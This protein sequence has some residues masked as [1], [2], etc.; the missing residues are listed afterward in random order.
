MFTTAGR[1]RSRPISC[2]L[3]HYIVRSTLYTP[4]LGMSFAIPLSTLVYV[5]LLDVVKL[6]YEYAQMRRHTEWTQLRSVLLAYSS[7]HKHCKRPRVNCDRPNTVKFR[8]QRAVRTSGLDWSLDPSSDSA[9]ND[10]TS[11]E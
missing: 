7:T 1:D 8:V 6:E 9:K 10:Y 3:I 5:Y 4:D 11:T 2:A